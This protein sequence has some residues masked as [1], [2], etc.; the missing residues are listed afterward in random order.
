MAEAKAKPDFH[1]G[2]SEG[3]SGAFMGI[4]AY[5]KGGHAASYNQSVLSGFKVEMTAVSVNV[6]K[7]DPH[8]GVDGIVIV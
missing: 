2:G 8:R 6:H 4:F 5:G 7:E 3:F 1:H